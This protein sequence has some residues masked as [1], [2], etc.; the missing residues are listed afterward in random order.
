LY[1]NRFQNFNPIYFPMS[2]QRSVKFRIALL[3]SL[4]LITPAMVAPVLAQPN[5]VRWISGF[6]KRPKQPLG[7]RT[8][9]CAITP[10]LV[11]TYTIETDRPLFLWQNGDA[12]EINLRLRGKKEPLWTGKPQAGDRQ[13]LFNHPEAL[14]PGIYQW[15]VLGLNSKESDIKVWRS[16]QVEAPRT[17]LPALKKTWQTK[18]Y[19]TEEIALQTADWYADRDRWSDAIQA[20]F[21]IEKPSEEFLALRSAYIK[22]LCP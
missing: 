1:L 4:L 11:G 9:L 17:E 12:I 22:E 14:K 16:F 21:D 13:I 15:Q 5:L 10:G 7:A 6:W 2:S 20:L 19:S 8:A 3:T 18:G